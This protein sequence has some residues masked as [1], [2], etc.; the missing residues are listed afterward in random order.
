MTVD[1]AFTAWL[2]DSFIAFTALLLLVLAVRR[3]VAQWLGPQAAYMLWLLP[4]ARWFIPPLM[5]PDA[6]RPFAMREAALPAIQM[7]PV[8]AIT[9]AAAPAPTG[10]AAIAPAI[11]AAPAPVATPFL[12]DASFDLASSALLLWGCTALFLF[13]LLLLHHARVVR[14]VRRG[15]HELGR[16]GRVR[17]MESPQAS[18]PL[19]V[20][21][22]HRTVF[23][24]TGARGWSLDAQQMAVAHEVTH[25][26]AGHLYHNHAAM[27]LLCL[28]WFNP[29]VWIAARAFVFDQEADCDARTLGRYR[30]DRAA[31]AQMLVAATVG[32]L[33]SASMVSPRAN[34]VNK[35]VIVRRIGRI[36]MSEK[37]TSRRL[38]G[39]GVVILS[40]V[41]LLPLTASLAQIDQPASPVPNAKTSASTEREIYYSDGETKPEYRRDITHKGVTYKVYTNRDVSDADIRRSLDQSDKARADAAVALRDAEAALRR[42][43]AAWGAAENTHAAA[44]AARS[45]AMQGAVDAEAIRRDA[46]ARADEARRQA[47]AGADEA[48][49]ASLAGAEEGRRQALAGA[50]Q[51]RRQALAG[52]DEA[53][54]ASLA[55]AEEARREALAGADQAR[56]EALA[57]AAEARRQALASSAEAMRQLRSTNWQDVRAARADAE[58]A[59]RSV[60]WNGV[61]RVQRDIIRSEQGTNRSTVVIQRDSRTDTE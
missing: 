6:L 46:W 16:V 61:N 50:D 18:G 23:I 7:P 25:H 15:A 34:L 51:A 45:Q 48:R 30:F 49:R 53:R 2:L 19:A 39:Y 41:A 26:R 11:P 40:G 59:V 32:S 24:P 33:P 14:S 42:N 28:N 36:S 55:G 52:A 10:V 20:G 22:H 56:R 38:L 35:S 12:P 9:A 44:D 4:A 60:D 8:E 3:P 5:L 1:A 21:L 54:R 43:R 13:A 31:Y 57:A 27:L 37:S 47:L 17:L 29:V 58:A